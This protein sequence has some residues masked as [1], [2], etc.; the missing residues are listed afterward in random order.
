MG[1]QLIK[2]E[3]VKAKDFKQIEENVREAVALVKR[4]RQQYPVKI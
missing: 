2:S 3:L 4:L 1:S